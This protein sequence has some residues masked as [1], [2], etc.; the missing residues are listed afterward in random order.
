MTRALELEPKSP[1]ILHERGK[2][3]YDVFTFKS[4]YLFQFWHLNNCIQV[5]FQFWHLNNCIQ[6]LLPLTFSINSGIINFRS[7]DFTAAV[8]D[9]SICLKQEKD[10]KSAYTYLVR[11]SSVVIL[12]LRS[13]HDQVYKCFLN[14]TLLT[15]PG[16]S[17]CISWWIYKSWRGAFEVYPAR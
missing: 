9:L 4:C 10:N 8:K 16:T 1:D 15:F 14:K 12:G 2:C 6:V 5:L 3:L 11:L 7:K 13:D 17:F